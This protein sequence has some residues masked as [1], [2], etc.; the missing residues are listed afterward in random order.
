MAKPKIKIPKQSLETFCRKYQVQRLAVFGSVLRDDFNPNSDVDI[1][2]VF[3]PSA[4][5]TFMKLG[6]MKRE[7]SAILQRP[8]D[9]IPQDGLKPAIRKEVLESAQVVYAA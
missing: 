2:V 3:D 8:V 6:Q 7:L 1:L 4:Q 5:V 9:I